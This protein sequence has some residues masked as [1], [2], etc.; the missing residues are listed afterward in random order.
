MLELL[1]NAFLVAQVLS[2]LGWGMNVLEAV[3]WS[4]RGSRTP[5]GSGTCH[6]RIRHFALLILQ[7][8][9]A[10]G[11]PGGHPRSRAMDLEALAEHRRLAVASSKPRPVAAHGLGGFRAPAHVLCSPSCCSR[12]QMENHAW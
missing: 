8:G 9:S 2:S 4:S 1:L 7:L 10:C 5:P 6:L 11:V 3:L 12:M